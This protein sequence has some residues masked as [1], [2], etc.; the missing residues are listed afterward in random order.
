MIKLGVQNI[1][2]ICIDGEIKYISIIPSVEEL[3]KAIAEVVNKKG[4]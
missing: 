1:P 3:R 4:L 2:T